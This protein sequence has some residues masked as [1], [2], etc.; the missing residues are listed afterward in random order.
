MW[1]TINPHSEGSREGIRDMPVYPNCYMF[2]MLTP[3]RFP[4]ITC[5]MVRIQ[6]C[7]NHM[8]NAQ[9]FKNKSKQSTY[10]LFLLLFS[11]KNCISHIL[12]AVFNIL[13]WG[14]SFCLLCWVWKCGQKQISSEH[15]AII[16]L[17]HLALIEV[18][19]SV[20]IT[21]HRY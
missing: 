8:L 10:Y 2:N 16:Y 13:Q 18:C 4:G 7:F 20:L 5:T 3:T 11:V 19:S 17:Y 6:F 9:F 1:K 21:Y 14:H 12:F 15:N